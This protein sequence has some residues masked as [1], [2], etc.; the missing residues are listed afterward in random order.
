MVKES[1]WPSLA[2]KVTPEP[3][4]MCRLGEVPCQVH[5]LPLAVWS[6]V[7]VTA[8]CMPTVIRPTSPPRRRCMIRAIAASA[9][10]I[11]PCLCER[12]PAGQTGGSSGCPLSTT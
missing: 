6:V 8:S 7:K 4:G 9:M 12:L 11:E 2:R 3:I 5:Q 1:Q 10:A